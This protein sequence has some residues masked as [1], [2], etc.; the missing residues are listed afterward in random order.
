MFRFGLD[1]PF[2]DALVLV[3][4]M[5]NDNNIIINTRMFSKIY[6]LHFF[7]LLIVTIV[8]LKVTTLEFTS[9]VAAVQ[10]PWKVILSVKL[11]RLVSCLTYCVKSK[12]N[13]IVF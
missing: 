3:Y 4:F 10:Y 13:K 9:R 6:I 7:Q 8:D 12:K 11:V 2:I 1:K 5:K